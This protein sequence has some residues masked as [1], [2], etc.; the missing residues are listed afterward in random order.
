M[1]HKI[2]RL[3]AILLLFSIEV[4]A[5]QPQQKSEIAK[6]RN[7]EIQVNQVQRD[8]DL[9][10]RKLDR[11]LAPESEPNLQKMRL[12]S[13]LHQIEKKVQGNLSVRA[14]KLM[15]DVHVVREK[16]R[17]MD[18]E[19]NNIRARNQA[20]SF[21]KNK[22]L[23]REHPATKKIP[24]GASTG[25]IS[26]TVTDETGTVPVPYTEVDIY[27]SNGDWT[28]YSYSD[29]NGAY[30]V[31]VEQGTYFARSYSYDVYIDELY[32]E[33]ECEPTCDATTGTPI[34]V[35]GNVGGIN[36][37]LDTPGQIAG[38]VTDSATNAPLMDI[39]ID[40]YDQD[41]NWRASGSTDSAGN[42]L[43]WGA[44]GSGSYFALARDYDQDYLAELYQELPCSGDCNILKGTPISVTHGQ[45]TNGIN[46]TLDKSGSI[47]GKVL[48]SGNSSPIQ[49]A[50][51][52][53]DANGNYISEGYT[54]SKGNYEAKGLTTG[55]Y[56]AVTDS[57]ENF[58]DELYDNRICYQ[59]FCEPTTGSPIS[60]T[61]GQTTSGINFLLDRAGIIRGHV[62][63]KNGNPLPYVYINI[64][65]SA[66]NHV[67]YSYT[68]ENGSYVRKGLIQGTYFA[69]TSN[70]SGYIDELYDNI[71]CPGYSCDPLTGTPIEVKNGDSR[72]VNFNLSPG[73]KIAG[74]VTDSSTGEPIEYSEISIYDSS[75]NSAGYGYSYDNGKYE[76]TGL[77]TGQYYAVTYNYDKY[78]D[79]LYN[80]HSCPFQQCDVTTGD[81]ISVTTAHTTSGID[82]SLDVG[83]S[84]SGTVT[85][86]N[87][88]PLDY[89]ATLV[90]DSQ[91]FLVRYGYSTD[92]NGHYITQGLP[93]GNFYQS[94]LNWNR[95]ADELYNNIPCT[96]GFCDPLSGTAIAVTT[97]SDTPG[98]DY[99]LD[100]G[101]TISGKLYDAQTAAPIEYSEVN[102]Y[103]SA[104]NNIAYGYADETGTYHVDYVGL[105]TGNYF[106]TSYAYDYDYVNELYD[107]IPCQNFCDVLTGTPIPVTVG[108]DTGN[109]DFGLDHG[110]RI[111]GR[112]ID[113]DTSIPVDAYINVYDASGNLVNYGY[114]YTDTGG[115]YVV[116]KLQSG[117]YFV[118]VSSYDHIGE[119]YDNIVC[120]GGSCDP[121]SG[122]P[123]VV[124]VA[125]ETSGIDFD[126]KTCSE[127]IFS[128]QVLPAGIVGTQY[129]QIISASGGAAPYQY[130]IEYGN[131]PGGITFDAAT[132]VIS[133]TP[134]AAGFFGFAIRATDS[135]GCSSE[136]TYSITVESGS[137]ELNDDFEDG[138]LAADWS[139]QG[140]W[141][142]SGGSLTSTATKK[143]IATSGS[144]F[145]GCVNCTL[146][147]TLRSNSTQAYVSVLGWYPN[148]KNYV[149]LIM[150]AGKDR[151]ILKQRSGGI[152]V[153]K[154]K[155]SFDAQPDVTYQVSITFDGINFVVSVN[156]QTII[157][158]PA[159][160]LPTA[161]KVGY[162]VKSTAGFFDYISVM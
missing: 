66:G 38:T 137:S 32:S 148:H 125:T 118:T 130:E 103:D 119:L 73:G 144:N 159:G 154:Q 5:K 7:L 48:N 57:Y 123:V 90:F 128:P 140:Q 77:P 117:S 42:Y 51:H 112:V 39:A 22:T 15:K 41:G 98:I 61:L 45:T 160:A 72:Q 155:A 86:S 145:I 121:L 108:S 23:K 13:Q 29:E 67:A 76:T 158:M 80:N 151:W 126:L 149:E 106:A 16:L 135:N 17:T 49:S 114:S 146:S 54:D 74:R 152:I 24:L 63:D 131:L 21:A 3:F 150:K 101:G 31:E 2:I 10:L 161:G 71:D 56:F 92:F 91:G 52:I 147:T 65:D 143:S 82:F 6:F 69:T 88:Q 87:S 64:Y 139:Y 25:L 100:P 28:N 113:V 37:T 141:A 97:G 26:G 162:E 120:P 50:V 68:D 83:G 75:G 156:N 153:A 124:T 55:T 157:T 60:V 134:T 33:I 94:T 78:V 47:A 79:E 46:F 30:S 89:F 11:G 104:G 105:S 34:V 14:L 43:T 85:T 27:D 102:I 1:S 129:D 107:N 111:S 110:G 18:R 58:I 62:K 127:S 9:Y 96:S 19:V 40:I 109:I 4:Y 95:Y 138:V 122:T 8:L 133:G 115:N 136:W 99:V 12:L 81:P 84:I 59:Q 132:G 44:L 142:E 53:Y 116:T 20:I 35:N 36:F 70:Y 93:T